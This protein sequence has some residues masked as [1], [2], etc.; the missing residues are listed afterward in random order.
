MKRKK[1]VRIGLVLLSIVVLCAIAVTVILRNELRSLASIRQIDDYKDAVFAARVCH[2]H[3]STIRHSAQ[4]V[5][6]MAQAYQK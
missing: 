3:L 4:Y 2:R 1:I 5:L 6:L